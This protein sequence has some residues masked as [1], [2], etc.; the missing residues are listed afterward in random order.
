[1]ELAFHLNR[2]IRPD[3]ASF[4]VGVKRDCGATWKPGGDAA[5]FGAESA[6]RLR[7]RGK[8]GGD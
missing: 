3:R 1:M 6:I 5:A 7:R 2:Q 8:V 4:S